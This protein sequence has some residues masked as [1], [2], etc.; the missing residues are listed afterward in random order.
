MTDLNALKD[1]VEKSG[2]KV[3][4]LCEKLG[5]SKPVWYARLA[6]KSLFK[7]TEIVALRHALGLTLKETDAIFFA[8]D[9]G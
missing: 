6:G 2:L 4:Y 1:R 3:S 9:N 5:I 8:S 7:P